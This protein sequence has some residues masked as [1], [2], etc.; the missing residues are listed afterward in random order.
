MTVIFPEGFV[1]GASSSAH[2]IEGAWNEDG[3]G[4][5]IWDR[6]AHTPGKILG[7]A[8]ADFACDH[9]HRW[10]GDVALMA[11]LG[12]SAYR[13]SIA[14]TRII[15]DGGTEIN[16]AGLAFYS[17]L[18]DA[19]L[20]HDIT[21]L[22][23]LF[24]W[25]LPQA[26]QDRGGWVKRGTVDAFVRYSDVVSSALGDRVQHWI[27]HN[28]PWVASMLGY[29]EGVHAPGIRGWRSALA[30]AHNILL[31]HGRAVPVLRQNS[32]G[33]QVGIALDCRPSYPASV[34]PADVKAERHFDGFRNRWFFD[35]VF[36]RGYPSDVAKVYRDAGRI[37]PQDPFELPG[38]LEEIAEPIDFLG[39]NYYTSV[40]VGAGG[41]ESDDPEVEPSPDPPDG[42]TEMGWK[43]TPEALTSFLI[44]IHEEYR[45]D[46]IL[47]TENGASYSDGP[48]EGQVVD[49]ERRI[50]YVRAHLVALGSAMDAGVPVGGYFYWSLMDN[51]EWALAYTQ[52][53]GLV[54]TDFET[55]QRIPKRSFNWYREV[56][57][58]NGSPAL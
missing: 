38:D 25:D 3:K 55:G 22:A 33:A 20:A 42:F 7:G 46:N 44:R 34:D 24:H 58:A 9:Y 47:I 36:G 8:N 39:L 32:P 23:T 12:V 45:P 6:F 17:D 54:W 5:S 11:E 56:I 40:P 52:R 16:P 15:P 18:V 53:F 50:A 35:P 26:L 10:R 41:E 2:Q 21:P 1:W 31:S 51:F 30:A 13:F 49:D 27:T 48:D 37:D 14:W 19:L 57:A 4:E 28:E 43:V 29:L